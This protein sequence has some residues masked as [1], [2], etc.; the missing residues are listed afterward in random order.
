MIKQSHYLP[1]VA[2]A[3]GLGESIKRSAMSFQSNKES[4]TNHSIQTTPHFPK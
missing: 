2:V 4:A 3:G 1:M